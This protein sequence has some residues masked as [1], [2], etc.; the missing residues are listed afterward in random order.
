MDT[1]AVMTLDPPS[2]GFADRYADLADRRLAAA[3]AAEDR[4]EDAGLDPLERATCRVHRRWLHRCI[5]SPVHVMMVT[6]HRWCRTCEASATVA[7]DEL[8]GAVR[9]TCSRCGRTP[10]GRATRQIVRCC[11][12]SMAA[13]QDRYR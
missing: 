1:T 6:G 4:A 10:E 8:A 11:M 13:A 2:S 7:I 5:A 3:L 9:V 12:A